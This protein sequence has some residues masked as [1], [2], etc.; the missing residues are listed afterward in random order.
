MINWKKARQNIPNKLRLKAKR[1]YE[2]LWTKEFIADAEQLGEARF[3]KKQI[4]LKIDQDDR[5]A[6]LS[7][8]H[9]ALHILSFEKEI[10]LTETQVR[11]LEE[12]FEFL[13]KLFSTLRKD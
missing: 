12:S 3:D 11:K 9:E 5:E 6:V 8:F 10:Q 4:L 7:Y 13:E 2:I 1:I